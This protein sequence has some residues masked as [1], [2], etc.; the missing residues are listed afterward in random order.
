VLN[1]FDLTRYPIDSPGGEDFARLVGRCREDLSRTGASVLESFVPPVQ[2]AQAIDEITP[3]IENAYS[4]TKTHSAYLIA[5]DDTFSPDHPRNRK[6][7]TSSATLAYD[8][9]PPQS[10]LNELYT[11]PALQGFL[12]HVLGYEMLYPY[13]DSLTPLNILVYKSGHETGW[14]FD[15]STFVVTLMLKSAES[16]GT[17][18]FAPFI[19]T[20]EDENFDGVAAVLEGRSDRVQELRQPAGALV[21]F[22]GSRTLHRVTPVGGSDP[23]LVAVLSYSPDVGVVSDPHNRKTFYGRIA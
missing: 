7:T 21:I 16:G 13:A 17:F 4:K 15:V 3:V 20:D 14:H 5:D 9:I 23:R 18:E 12:A 19:R 1:V 10:L 22:R 6:Q 11:W 2:L 8:Y